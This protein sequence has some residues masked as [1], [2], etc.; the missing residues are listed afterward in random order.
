MKCTIKDICS[1]KSGKRLPKGAIFSDEITP[2][3]Y[4]RARDIKAGRIYVDELAFLTEEVQKR[5]AQYIVN[6]N[7]VV[8]TIV[9]ASVGDVGFVTPELNGFNLTENAVRLTGFSKCV[10]PRYLLY[11]LNSKKYWELMQQIAGG[12]AQPKLGIYKIESIPLELPSIEKQNSI[13]EL[14]STYDNLIENNQK[15]IKLLEEAAQRLYKEW[16]V[17]LRF[18]GHEDMQIV[19]GVPE[20][21]KIVSLDDVISKITTGLNPRKNFVL[22]KGNN[23][24]V[25][26]KNM[27]DNNIYLDDKCDKIDDEALEKINKR[28]DLRT[29]DIL[30]SGIGT[31]GRVYLIS[32]PTNNWNVSESVFTMRVNER[33]TNEY[34]YMVLLSDDMKSYCD[35]NA[36]GVAQRGIRMADLR[37]Y[38]L[39]LPDDN[40]LKIYTFISKPLIQKVQS[41]QKQCKELTEARDRLLPKL[42]S[43]EIEL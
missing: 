24:Y 38:K 4:I 7:D 6:T 11:V 9:G 26:I 21:W 41:L 14:L 40:T 2:Y 27:G 1:I 12:S 5:I 15:Q 8:I 32:I 36:H 19:D 29:G 13:V 16:F 22:G 30:F 39:F 33:I 37:A 3:P 43:G 17:D 34:L 20:G 10:N 25:T 35:Q 23:F 28:S 31:M 18:P 42:M